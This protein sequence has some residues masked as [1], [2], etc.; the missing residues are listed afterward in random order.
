[1]PDQGIWNVSPREARLLA[2]R[3][4]NSGSFLDVAGPNRSIWR[5]P[6][7]TKIALMYLNWIDH[8]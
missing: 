2:A 7:V 4:Q 1:M 8:L 5:Y 3:E 6:Q